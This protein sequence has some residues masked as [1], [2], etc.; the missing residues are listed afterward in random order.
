MSVEEALD[1]WFAIKERGSSIR[2]ECLAGLTSFMA[3]CYLIFVIPDMLAD[4]GMPREAAVA[5]TIWI[6]VFAT[7]LMGLWAKF[8]VGVAPGLG[9]SAYFAYY[10]CGPAGYTWQEGLGAVFFSG[11]IFLAL[12]VTKIR[13]MLIDAVPM[14]MKYS[15]VAGIG[16]FIAFIGMKNCG[17]IVASPST[18]VALG[19]LR[20]PQTLLAIAGIFIIAI[21]LARGFKSAMLI[22]IFTVTLIGMISGVSALPQ[23][24]IFSPEALFPSQLFLQLDFPGLLTH[25]LFTIVFT[26]TMVDLFDNMGVLIGLSQKA[27]FMEKDGHIKN[28]DKALVTDSI[29][30]MASGVLGATTATSYLESAA[31][32]ASGGKTGLTALVIAGLFS[33]SLFC[34]PLIAVVPAYATAPVL[35]VVGA[36]M[37]QEVTNIK[38]SDLTIAVPAFLTII[39]MPLT[40]NIATGFGFGFISYVLMK[41]GTGKF[42]EVNFLM[43]IIAVCFAVS[44]VLR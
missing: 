44:F 26:L 24:I 18:F 37:M 42:R 21:L 10:V 29:A 6:T 17:I 31:G 12:T 5:S 32:V 7:L 34:V 38:F 33:L 22:G 43:V 28:L 30:T 25:G 40:F 41:A 19:N 4:A 1:K 23:S 14:D 2:T 13:Q 39:S 3:M 16:A 36:L 35:I 15:I 8:P 20:S 11:L 27:G 9:I